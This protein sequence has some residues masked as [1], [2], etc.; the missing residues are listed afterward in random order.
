MH[1]ADQRTFLIHLVMLAAVSSNSA[2][3]G[4]SMSSRADTSFLVVSSIS[5]I[6]KS[7]EIS[8]EKDINR[9]VSIF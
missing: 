9:L 6:A 2:E 3:K 4:S 1:E 5:F 7:L 8:I